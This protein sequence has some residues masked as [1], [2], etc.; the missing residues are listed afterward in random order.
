[1][2][3]ARAACAVVAVLA[4]AW[5]VLGIHQAHDLNAATN[6]ANQG[7]KISRADAQKVT[8]LVS[9]ARTLNPDRQLDIVRGQ[10]LLEAGQPSAAVRI[11]LPV[12]RDEPRNVQGWVW[13]AHAAGGYSPLFKRALTKVAQLDPDLVPKHR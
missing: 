13:L 4:A 7:S 1:M 12:T 9:N 10:A 2:R 11:L 5:F 3:L 6:I 8:S